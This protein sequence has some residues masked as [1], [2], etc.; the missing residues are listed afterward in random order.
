MLKKQ[1]WLLWG[2]VCSAVYINKLHD[3]KPLVEIFSTY[4]FLQDG[5]LLWVFIM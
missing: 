2:T 4:V 5:M 3:I 1:I